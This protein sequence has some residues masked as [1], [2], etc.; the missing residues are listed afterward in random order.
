MAHQWLSAKP[1]Y[2]RLVYLASPLTHDD[3]E[4]RRERSVAVARA[5]G[6]LMNNRHDVFFLSPVAHGTP[7]AAECSLPY[8]WSFWAEIDEC[9]LSRC[10]EIWVLCVTGFKLSLIHI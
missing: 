4:V 2:G 6:W 5:C 7:I 8:E 9:W 1:H 3:A 10:E